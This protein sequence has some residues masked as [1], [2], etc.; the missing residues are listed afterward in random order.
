MSWLTQLFKDVEGIFVS[1]KAQVIEQD[2]AKLV[3]Q[4]APIVASISKLVPNK[5]IQEVTAAYTNYALTP[6]TAIAD[7]PTSIGN[8]MLNLG[9][10]LLQKL[11]PNSTV[12]ALNSAIQLAVAAQK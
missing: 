2:I 5:T 4:A 10:N 7:N 3:V 9:T 1:P 11:S 6:A 12:T 8:A